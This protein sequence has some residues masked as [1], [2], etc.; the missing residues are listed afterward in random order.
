MRLNMMENGF[1]YLNTNW[2]FMVSPCISAFLYMDM[3][4]C[5]L[6]LISIAST[7]YAY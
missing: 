2:V 1:G 6:N 5:F 7:I 4:I 3:D